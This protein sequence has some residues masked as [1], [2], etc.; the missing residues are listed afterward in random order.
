[1]KPCIRLFYGQES[2][3]PYDTSS[4]FSNY[5]LITTTISGKIDDQQ[6]FRGLYLLIKA[7]NSSL[8]NL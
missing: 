7:P 1:M 6:S 4:I 8:H 2:T 3:G 5:A